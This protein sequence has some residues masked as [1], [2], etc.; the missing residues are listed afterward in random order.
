[1]RTSVPTTSAI[2]TIPTDHASPE[3]VLGLILVVDSGVDAIG[4]EGRT[5]D[6]FT[7]GHH[8]DVRVL[9]RRPHSASAAAGVA[10]F[11]GVLPR[12]VLPRE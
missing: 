6:E 12:V 10:R 1:M 5:R 7:V 9:A 4:T 3:A 11:L 2:E 8:R